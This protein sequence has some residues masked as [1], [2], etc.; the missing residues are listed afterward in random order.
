MMMRRYGLTMTAL[1]NK[2]TGL[3]NTTFEKEGGILHRKKTAFPNHLFKK[4]KETDSRNSC[5]DFQDKELRKRIEYGGTKKTKELI[6]WR[7]GPIKDL[8]LVPI[9]Y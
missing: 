6:R 2:R 4:Y 8:D 5:F 9:K 1:N 3:D 7:A